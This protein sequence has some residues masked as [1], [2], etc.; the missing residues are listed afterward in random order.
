MGKT[1]KTSGKL[2]QTRSSNLFGKYV[3]AII[4]NSPGGLDGF[5]ESAMAIEKTIAGNTD[6]RGRAVDLVW[7]NLEPTSSN[8][9]GY[10][11]ILSKM[12][13]TE[14]EL[15]AVYVEA[16][17]RPYAFEQFY[18]KGTFSAARKLYTDN[19]KLMKG[20]PKGKKIKE[21]SSFKY[22]LVRDGMP[23]DE[24]FQSVTA[25]RRYALR[26]VSGLHTGY[27]SVV[28]SVD[29]PL[30]GVRGGKKTFMGQ[31]IS[32]RYGSAIWWQENGQ[33]NAINRDGTL[34]RRI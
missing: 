8:D 5:M 10:R 34:G 29:R 9:K 30:I 21:A 7:L 3:L 14:P 11:R 15:D 26:F 27:I 18:Q 19:L 17:N 6:R 12:G 25:A 13:F 28:K 4:R 22:W 20:T 33:K 16:A 32:D 23:F 31:I 24:N 1:Y 2:S